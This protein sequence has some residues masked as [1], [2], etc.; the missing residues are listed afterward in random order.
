MNTHWL[1]PGRL[2]RAPENFLG[3]AGLQTVAHEA[4]AGRRDFLRNAFAAASGAAASAALAQANRLLL[5]GI[6]E[7]AGFA[8][9]PHEWWHYALPQ[10]EHYPLLG[11]ASLGALN[12]MAPG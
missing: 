2:R 7:G 8:H 12:P 4:R 9:I 5:L 6:M 10:P 3:R 11:S 1:N